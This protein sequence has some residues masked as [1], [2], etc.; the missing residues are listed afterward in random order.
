MP[1][2][3][4]RICFLSLSLWVYTDN[5][6]VCFVPLFR[7]SMVLVALCSRLPVAS[8]VAGDYRS[9]LEAA[10]IDVYTMTSLMTPYLRG[11]NGRLRSVKTALRDFDHLWVHSK[12]P[13]TTLP[14]SPYKNTHSDWDL[15]RTVFRTDG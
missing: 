9:S 3:N 8:L 6:I 7:S 4:V 14:P 11:G 2:Y 12:A 10:A 15:H 13:G 5:V 1:H